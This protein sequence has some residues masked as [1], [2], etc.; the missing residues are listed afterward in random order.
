[1]SIEDLIPVAKKLNEAL[2][3]LYGLGSA[4]VGTGDN[5]LYIYEHRELP[6]TD[7][8]P[9]RSFQYDGIDVKVIFVGKV[10]FL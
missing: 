3:S 9:D 4:S 8:V 5:T 6:V 2:V 1:M 7:L 10:E